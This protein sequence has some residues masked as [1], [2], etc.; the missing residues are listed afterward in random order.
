MSYNG[1]AIP[2]FIV[3]M[4]AKEGVKKFRVPILIALIIIVIIIIVVVHATTEMDTDWKLGLLYGFTLG[5][6]GLYL[7]LFG[8]SYV[9]APPHSN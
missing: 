2:P 7:I 9:V 3:K 6:V 5:P 4:I 8:L 1:G